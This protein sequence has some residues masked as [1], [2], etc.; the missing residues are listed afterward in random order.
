[1]RLPTLAILLAY[2]ATAGAADAPPTLVPAQLLA[3][4]HIPATDDYYPEVSRALKEQGTVSL[5]LCYNQQGKPVELSVVKSSGFSR[6]DSAALRWGRSVRIKPAIITGIAR[7]GCVSIRAAF[8]LEPTQ[9]SGESRGTQLSDP[10]I[11][12]PRLPPPPPPIGPIPLAP[13]V[14]PASIPLSREAGDQWIL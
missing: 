11:I 14:P 13:A 5:A 10:P 1:M 8:S 6:L 3:Y 12:W 7:S 4:A 9:G 2:A